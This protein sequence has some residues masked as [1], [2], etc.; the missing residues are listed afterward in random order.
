MSS[1]VLDFFE[2]DDNLDIVEIEAAIKVI[3]DEMAPPILTIPGI[4]YRMGAMI[5]AE[6]G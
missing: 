1:S 5:L 6:I 2:I 4:S 3:V